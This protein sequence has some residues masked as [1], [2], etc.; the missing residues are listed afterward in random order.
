MPKG[1]IAFETMAAGHLGP[2]IPREPRW[3]IPYDRDMNTTPD[4]SFSSSRLSALLVAWNRHE[5]LRREG[6]SIADLAASRQ[7]L[8]AIRYSA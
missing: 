2:W 5:N 7:A 8:D 4:R 6:A 3:R 1:L